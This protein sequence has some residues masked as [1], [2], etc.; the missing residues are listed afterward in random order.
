MPRAILPGYGPN[1]RTVMQVTIAGTAPRAGVRPDQ[2]QRG[3]PHKANGSGVFESG[4]HP[5]IVG[6]AAYNSAYG[7]SFAGEQQLQRSGQHA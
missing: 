3:L 4:Q 5:V 6:Q 1:T 2:A 7:T